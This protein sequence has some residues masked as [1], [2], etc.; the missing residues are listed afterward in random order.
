MVFVDHFLHDRI[1]LAFL[2]EVFLLG[3]RAQIGLQFYLLLNVVLVF[4][5][6]DSANLLFIEFVNVGSFFVAEHLGFYVCVLLDVDLLAEL[7]LG[8]L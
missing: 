8:H 3:L 5:E 2:L 6:L 1:D 4:E 7:V